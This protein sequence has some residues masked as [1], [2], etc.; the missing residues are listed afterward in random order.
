MLWPEHKRLTQIN[1]GQSFLIFSSKVLY[2]EIHKV[3]PRKWELSI[4]D[5][6]E[7]SNILLCYE[8]D[9]QCDAV[10]ILWKFAEKYEG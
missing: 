7:G 9:R 6:K 4:R 1:M 8:Y 2:A 10:D 3:R 5:A